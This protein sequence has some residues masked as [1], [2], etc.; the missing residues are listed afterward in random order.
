MKSDVETL[1]PTRVKLTVEVPF[2]ELKPSVDAA[3]KSIGAQI[4]VPGFRKGKVPA[5]I[6][7]QR[8]GRGAVLQEAIN[9]ALPGLFSKAADEQ[10]I[11][12]LGQ[13]DVDITDVPDPA[14]G[15]DL[16]FTVEVDVRPEVTLPE[17]SSL[18]VQIDDYEVT[19]ADVDERLDAL[20]ERFGT[21]VGV[22]RPAGE[23]DFVSLD[24]VAKIGDEEIDSAKGISYQVGAGNMIDGL[25]EALTGLS[26]GEETTF[27]APLAGG[28]HAGETAQITV[29]AVS[30][31]ERELPEADDEFAELASEFETIAE[32]KDDLR[33]QAA[34]AK[35]F[36]AGL[37][38]RDKVLEALLAAVDVPVPEKLVEAEVH[39]HLEGENRLEDDEHRAEVTEEVTTA[40]RT[41]FVLDTI[42]DKEE[43]SVTQGELIEYLVAQAPRYGMDANA[44]A[45]AVDQAGQVPAMVGEVARRKGLAVVLESATITDV[46][47]Q[48]VDLDDLVPPR[49]AA[50]VPTTTRATTTRATTTRATT[51]RATTTRA[52]ATVTATP[53]SP[54]TPPPP[55]RWARSSSTTST[56]SSSADSRRRSCGPRARRLAAPRSWTAR[57]RGDGAEPRSKPTANTRRV[58]EFG[59][60]VPR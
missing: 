29:T 56:S 31:K 12:P 16:K 8:V 11:R 49:P 21:L 46:N 32:L 33:G 52:T 9:E 55:S 14:Q 27:E 48:P 6:I 20:R 2:E 53:P 22:D 58:G 40:L 54:A 19:D 4:T 23:G 1:N 47:G 60:G 51:T 59:V 34:Q 10:K 44:F 5:R 37:G 28:E 42:V 41:Q 7:D 17:Y 39:S 50:E 30:V 13:P 35:K 24:L 36:Q 45:Q 25:D 18:A 57:P 26:A 15:G 3:Y 43:V 38:A